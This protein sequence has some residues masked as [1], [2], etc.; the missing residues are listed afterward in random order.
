MDDHGIP[1]LHAFEQDRFR[2]GQ[3][4]RN[5]WRWLHSQGITD[6]VKL[7]PESEGSDSCAESLSMNIH[8]FPI[9]WWRQM[10]IRPSQ[11]LLVQAVACL[12]PHVFVHCEHGEDRTGLVVGCFRLSQGWTKQDA[13]EEMMAFNFHTTLQALMG[14]WNSENPADWLSLQT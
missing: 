12:K 5:G 6:V 1:N 8:Y 13:F 2:G 4:T 3:P 7:N 14:R 10:F 11:S 9:P